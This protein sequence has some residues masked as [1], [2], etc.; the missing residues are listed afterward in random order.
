MD[1]LKAFLSGKKVYILIALGALTAILQYVADVDFGMSGLPV[2][3][4]IPELIQ[5]LYVFAV[6]AATRAAIAK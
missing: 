6:G 4:T 2:A 1:K 5:E 3:H